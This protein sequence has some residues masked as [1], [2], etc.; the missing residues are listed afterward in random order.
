MLNVLS[1]IILFIPYVFYYLTL[2]RYILL[3]ITPN[4]WDI[5]LRIL[6]VLAGEVSKNLA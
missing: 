6:V 3:Q 5:I 4:I 1:I 2:Q